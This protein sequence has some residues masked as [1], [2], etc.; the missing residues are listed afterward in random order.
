[1]DLKGLEQFIIGL[2]MF[3][4]NFNI[5]CAILKRFISL[6]LHFNSISGRIEQKCSCESWLVLLLKH[7][8]E[9]IAN[10]LS[11][12]VDMVKVPVKQKWNYVNAI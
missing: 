11:R 2:Q 6:T 9:M 7:N 10:R 4:S 8:R 1:M 5:R 12:Y 3:Q